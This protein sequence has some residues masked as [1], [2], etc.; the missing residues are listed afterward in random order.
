MIAFPRFAT[1]TS[2]S[3]RPF[4]RDISPIPEFPFLEA[5][6]VPESVLAISRKT[7]IASIIVLFLIVGLA[8]R[9][10]PDAQLERC[11]EGFLDAFETR[12]WSAVNAYLSPEYHDSWGH[13]RRQLGRDATYALT[14]FR[15]LEVRATHTVIERSG[16]RA[17]IEAVIRVVGD[18][19]PR[20]EQARQ[21]VNRVFVP[22]TFAWE[23]RPWRPWDWRLVRITN[24]E[25]DLPTAYRD[26][27]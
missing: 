9:W 25:V 5:I 24:E 1:R 4:S 17:Q 26:L 13:T 10:Q 27:L 12:R 7:W 18:G 2:K 14:D 21:A 22:T 20:A 15:T 6:P 23:R 19:G 11:W 16:R 3:P 8:I